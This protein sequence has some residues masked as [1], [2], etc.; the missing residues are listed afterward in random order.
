MSKD[1]ESVFGVTK[2]S[3]L[4]VPLVEVKDSEFNVIVSIQQDGRIFWKGR[5]VETD[6]D[7]RSAM[8]SLVKHLDIT[9]YDKR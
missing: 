3:E 8:M 9:L 5:E 4:K 2:N 6:E 1:T 7:F